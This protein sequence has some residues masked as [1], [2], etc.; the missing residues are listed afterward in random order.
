MYKRDLK[1][2]WVFRETFECETQREIDTGESTLY[3]IYEHIWTLILD[4]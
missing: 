1:T 4:F 2:R 3:I